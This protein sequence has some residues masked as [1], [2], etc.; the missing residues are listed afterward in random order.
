MSATF[1]SFHGSEPLPRYP[2]DSMITGVMN[3]RAI[4]A[5]SKIVLKQS[6][7][8]DDARTGTG[9]SPFRP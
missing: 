8:V 1:G 5:A 6:L 3:F 2:S 9:A 7:G 4:R